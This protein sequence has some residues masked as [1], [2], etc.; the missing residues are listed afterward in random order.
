MSGNQSF[1]KAPKP[2]PDL[3]T[4]ARQR[5]A[6]DPN[7]SAWV[8]ANAGSG[9]T[10]VLSTRVIRL[11][12]EG[13]EPS[14]ILC[15]T[16]TKTAAAEMKNRVFS[17]LGEWV[18]MDDLLLSR[19][20]EEITDKKV[21]GAQIRFARTL[22]AKALET[23]G[24][25]KIQTIHAFCEALLHRFPLEA[26]IAGHFELIDDM[27]SVYLIAE[28][29]R[30]LLLGQ[31]EEA[32]QAIQRILAAHGESNLE[33]LLDEIISKRQ[34]LNKLIGKIGDT[35]AE[36]RASYFRGLDIDVGETA[37]TIAASAWPLPGLTQ[38]YCR[39]IL[40]MIPSAGAKKALELI[41]NLTSLYDG[42]LTLPCL[43]DLYDFFFTQKDTLKATVTEKAKHAAP[44]I[45]DRILLAASHVQSVRYRLNLLAEIDQTLDAL[46]IA[47][48]L[49]AIYADLKNKR[50]LLD[51]E[52]VIARTESM[53]LKNNV[54]AWVRYKLDQ[55]IDHILVDEAQD[56]SPQQWQVIKTLADEF[57]SGEGA[58]AIDRTVFAVGDEKQSIYSFQG[59]DPAEFGSAR[60]HFSLQLRNIQRP[61]ESVEL[62]ASFRST[63]DILAAVDHVFSYADHKKGIA[64]ANLDSQKHR[65][66]RANEPGEV[67]VW[68]IE[69]AESTDEP[70][71]WRQ[72]VD[73]TAKPAVIVASRV[74]ARIK[75][76]MDNKECLQ[77]TGK[78]IKAGDILVLVRKRD[79]FVNA[80]SKALKDLKIPVAGTDRLKMTNHIAVLDLIA[81]GRVVLNKADDLS[82][83]ALLRSPLFGWSDD[84]LFELSYDRS[85]KTLYQCLRDNCDQP[86]IK[87]VFERLEHWRTLANHLPVFEFYSTILSADGARAQLIGRL[88]PEAS[89]MID[90][91]LNYALAQERTGPVSLETFIST[92]DSYGPEI[93]REMD[94]ARDEVRIMTVHG[95]KGLEAPIVFLIDPGSAAYV[96]PN[97]PKLSDCPLSNGLEKPT[98]G[99]LWMGSGKAKSNKSIEI[100]ETL[101]E[102]AVE[103]YNRLLYVGMTRAADR[104][105]V[106]GYAGK[107]GGKDGTWC[108]MVHKSLEPNAL[109]IE[110]DGFSAIKFPAVQS[111][112]AHSARGE[113]D[114]PEEAPIKIPPC[115]DF[116]API[117]A[118]AKRP[119]MPS[120]ASGLAIEVDRQ[121]SAGEQSM[122]LLKQFGAVGAKYQMSAELAARRGTVI[123]KLLQMLPDIVPTERR[124][125][126]QHYCMNFDYR[127][128]Q[129]DIDDILGQVFSVLDNPRYAPFFN[130]SALSEVSIMGTLNIGGEERA[131]SG[132]IDRLVVTD[133][134]VYIIDYKT[135]ANPPRD[136]DAIPALYLRQM[137]LYEALVSPLYPTKTVT[138]ALLFT[139]TPQMMVLKPSLLQDALASLERV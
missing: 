35:N 127:W 47:D 92:L 103:E 23:P 32:R 133:D 15:L 109:Q 53:L 44:D 94:V 16:Y 118:P 29:R 9:K 61:F 88:G 5:L 131:V 84:A 49:L 28:A 73:H 57:F 101:K 114:N 55:G 3:I 11:L 67:E 63:G 40:P 38:E 30:Q 25:L 82:L 107:T 60:D 86:H 89:D 105:I 27:A 111:L 20:L 134:S 96:S 120:G 48:R 116:P 7:R 81:L 132:V 36:R 122:S 58:R 41:Q 31:G 43:A 128:R 65:S 66:L 121:D 102:K 22:F 46:T 56:T 115:F 68:E 108:K 51:F 106:A 13:V 39:D 74:A 97:S 33:K 124:S 113:D 83:A 45:D 17:R 71:D 77:A 76:W 10:Y 6:S 24:G 137:A 93:K 1:D 95:A 78:N 119:L 18:T 104:L 52:D 112:L 79:S 138:A 135:N 75:Y 87:P 129:N 12:L 50:G 2:Q 59:A 136:M 54:A 80:L 21:S 37:E 126:A 8:S 69:K 42:S 85:P 98:E 139:A 62:E 14:K 34:K 99:L 110:C 123:H 72:P 130:N 70:E 91:F 125:R 19:T 4:V 64:A 90:A 26:N 117:E 100:N